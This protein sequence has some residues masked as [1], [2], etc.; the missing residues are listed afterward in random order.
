M[1]KKVTACDQITALITDEFPIC[2][3]SFEFSKS[4][5]FGY[6]EL[7]LYVMSNRSIR[8]WCIQLP[9]SQSK[10]CARSPPGVAFTNSVDNG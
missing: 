9:T 6:W 2:S 3:C 4:H 5:T 7:F 8:N 1:T 10:L